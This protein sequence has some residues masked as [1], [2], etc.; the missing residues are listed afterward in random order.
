MRWR[1]GLARAFICYHIMGLI[2]GI[3]HYF[4]RTPTR[5]R[6]VNALTMPFFGYGGYWALRSNPN[7]RERIKRIERGEQ[8]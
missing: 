1:L 7:I 8:P 2:G 6:I 5:A 3:A 4:P